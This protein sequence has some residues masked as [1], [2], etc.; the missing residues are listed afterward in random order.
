[1]SLAE[2]APRETSFDGP[3][4]RMWRRSQCVLVR[5]AAKDAISEVMETIVRMITAEH[6]IIHKPSSNCTAVAGEPATG[7]HT[8]TSGTS[9]A[10]GELTLR[11]WPHAPHPPIIEFRATAAKRRVYAGSS[12]RRAIIRLAGRSRQRAIVQISATPVTV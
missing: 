8:P 9:G 10:T 7:H 1:V 12:G 2:I 6:Q 3:R 11:G 5:I 4:P